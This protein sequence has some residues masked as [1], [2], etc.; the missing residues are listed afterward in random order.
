[1]CLVAPLRHRN[2]R[3][4]CHATPA[5]PPT[6]PTPRGETLKPQ[7]RKILRDLPSLVDIAVPDDG[8][9]TVCGDV[10]G[11]VRRPSREA[12]GRG[13][14]AWRCVARRPSSRVSLWQA[15]GRDRR[16]RHRRVRLEPA[17]PRFTRLA[18]ANAPHS[19]LPWPPVLRPAQH[20]RAQR[21]A[22]GRQ[23]LPLQRCA[24]L[25]LPAPRATRTHAC[26]RPQTRPCMCVSSRRRR[27]RFLYSPLQATLLTAARSAW[28]SYSPCWPGRWGAGACGKGFGAGLGGRASGRG[29][30]WGE[31]VLA[32]SRLPAVRRE[33][34][35]ACN[36]V[37][38]CPPPPS[39]A[40]PRL[41]APE[42]RQ[43]RE[44][45]HEQ[46]VRL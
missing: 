16:S 18:L 29:E 11:Q 37:R 15:G 3:C 5:T 40:G 39:G 28:R 12:P 10:H 35:G 1:M 6:T 31:R 17:A 20:F 25:T 45:Q 13:G 46:D 41:H 33:R 23:P 8:H 36:P 21:A 22:W 7:A 26:R 34:A 9:I 14:M 43:P 38:T 32:A 19:P 44:P 24:A 30:G 27:D 4:C 42:P 2:R